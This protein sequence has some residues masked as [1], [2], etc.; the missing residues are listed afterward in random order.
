MLVKSAD[1]DSLYL[2][3]LL[4]HLVS[5]IVAMEPESL[6]LCFC[7][8]REARRLQSWF[9]IKAKHELK[10]QNRIGIWR[11]LKWI[12]KICMECHVS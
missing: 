11:D 4:S 1:D 2:D 9:S 5:R 3:Y 7:P 6:L 8:Y 12:S 10:I